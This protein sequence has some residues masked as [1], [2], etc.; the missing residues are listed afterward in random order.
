MLAAYPL[1]GFLGA[2]PGNATEPGRQARLRL[3]T[4]GVLP[5][6]QEDIVTDLI[7][8]VGV[9]QATPQEAAQVWG[10]ALVEGIK[11]LWLAGS[12]LAQE[13]QLL[14]PGRAS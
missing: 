11:R 13:L 14:G 8:Q 3:E 6:H 10:I 12:H 4:L 2:V 7:H 1:P 9:G 5:G